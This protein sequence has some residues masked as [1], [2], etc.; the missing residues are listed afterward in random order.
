MN[1]VEAWKTVVLERYAQ[2]DGRAARPEF[3]WFALA[4]FIVAVALVILIQV[5]GIFWLLY[6]AYVLGVIIPSIAVAVRRLHDTDKSGWWYLIALVPFV[7][8]LILLILLCLEGTPGPNQ[9][10]AGPA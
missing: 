5:S 2:F 9:Y 1:P 10:G 4:N 8:G 7:G 6:V 3:W